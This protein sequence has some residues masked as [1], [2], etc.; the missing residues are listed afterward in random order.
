MGDVLSWL[1]SVSARRALPSPRKCRLSLHRLRTALVRGPRAPAQ[2]LVVLPDAEIAQDRYTG[3]NMIKRKFKPACGPTFYLRSTTV[4]T[5][6]SVS[7]PSPARPLGTATGALGDAAAHLN[8]S[9]PLFCARLR[10]RASAALLPSTRAAA[11]RSRCCPP[12]ARRLR[13]ASTGGGQ[14]QDDS[15]ITARRCPRCRCLPR[16]GS[17]A[18]PCPS[19]CHSPS[20]SELASCE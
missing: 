8:G 17:A 11:L 4:I 18:P 1:C 10:H 15:R 6:P 3:D 16:R 20:P 7:R 14:P 19:S 9:T 13:H 5:M 12:L 2:W